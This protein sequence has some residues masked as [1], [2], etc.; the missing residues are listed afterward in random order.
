MHNPTLR[1]YLQ[2]KG[3]QA[4]ISDRHICA[5]QE[6]VWC[7]SEVLEPRASSKECPWNG[8]PTLRSVWTVVPVSLKPHWW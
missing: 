3:L 2:G 4:W 5:Y 8:V 1:P 6:V 7:T